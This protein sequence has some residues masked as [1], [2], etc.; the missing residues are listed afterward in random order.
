M[1]PGSTVGAY[2]AAYMIMQRRYQTEYL[3]DDHQ[4][5]CDTTPVNYTATGIIL[6]AANLIL[7]GV[8]AYTHMWLL[9]IVSAITLVVSWLACF[10]TSGK[11]T[12]DTHDVETLRDRE[13]NTPTPTVRIKATRTQRQRR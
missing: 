4:Y 2:V 10:P 3:S 5:E 12:H 9:T 8:T 13:Q 11:R 7:I 1:N 6:T